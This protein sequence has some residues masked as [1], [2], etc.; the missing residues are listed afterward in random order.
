M[1]APPCTP[2]NAITG[3]PVAAARSSSAPPA[4]PHST[5][6]S[7]SARPHA[8]QARQ[9]ELPVELHAVLVLAGHDQSPLPGR[10]HVRRQ[11]RG[12][13]GVARE[14]PQH[15]AAVVRRVVLA[16]RLVVARHARPGRHRGEQREAGGRRRLD[17]LGDLARPQRPDQGERAGI[18]SRRL[19]RAHRVASVAVGD[20]LDPAQHLVD[21]RRQRGGE[22]RVDAHLSPRRGS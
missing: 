2:S 3:S 11:S 12:D 18:P 16:A 22:R 7:A 20:V 4:S 1:G 19:G 6:R 8:R 9:R 15:R 5:T 14:D 10:A 17:R 21:R 13:L